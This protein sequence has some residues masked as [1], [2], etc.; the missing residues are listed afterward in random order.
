MSSSGT[1]F[2]TAIGVAAI[3]FVA[4]SLRL[5]EP[6]PGPPAVSDAAAET[7]EDPAYDDEN[8]P[9]GHRLER[10]AD[11][12]FYASATVNGA[13]MRFLV[14][15]GSTVVALTPSDAEAAGIAPGEARTTAR[16]ANGEIE[17]APVVIDRIA[18]GRVEARDVRAVVA[19]G[20]PMSLLGQSF[21]AETESVE[22]R[23]DAMVLR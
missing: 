18:I 1:L 10:S 6:A 17:V 9:S 4:P 15:T 12:H 7:S 19:E 5:D 14:D 22:I 2:W 3:A 11:G 16:G 8:A 13:P 20:L 21:L 23:G